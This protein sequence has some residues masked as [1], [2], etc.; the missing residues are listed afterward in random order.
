MPFDCFAPLKLELTKHDPAGNPIGFPFPMPVCDPKGCQ[1]APAG[2]ACDDGSVCTVDD[3]CDGDGHCI[4]GAPRACDGPCLGCDPVAGCVPKPATARCDDGNACT[5]GE[6]CSGVGN[7]CIDG[8]P[9]SCAGPCLTGSCDPL[10]GCFPRAADASCSDA[11]VCTVGDH[12]SGTSDVCVPGSPVACDGA[13]QTGRCDKVLGCEL[14]PRT[15]VCDDGNACTV[16]DHCSGSSTRCESGAPRACA[17]SCLTGACD[18]QLGCVA[19]DGVK[20]LTCRVDECSRAH[21]RRRLEELATS[22]DHAVDAGGRPHK[23]AIRRLTR[24]LTRCGVLTPSG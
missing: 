15:Q 10:V 7:D 21:L 8:Q 9:V 22:I 17:G 14:A 20:A 24:L 23:R 1:D 6:H 11:D 13:C 12:C 18:P 19:K 5:T 16:G 4:G 2:A 3:R